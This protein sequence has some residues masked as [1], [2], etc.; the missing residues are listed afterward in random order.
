[1]EMTYFTIV[2]FYFNDLHLDK[3]KT[4]YYSDLEDQGKVELNDDDNDGALHI[5]KHRNLP[6]AF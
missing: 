2:Y 5:I 6:D 1:M 4:D 3:R